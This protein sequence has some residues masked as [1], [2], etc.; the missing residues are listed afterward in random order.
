MSSNPLVSVVTPSYNQEAFIEDALRS[1]INQDYP[2]VEH[3][4][5][6][7]G[8]TDGTIDILKKY[9]TEYNLRWSS[10][11]DNGQSDAVNKG[12]DKAE[13][14]IVGWLN[15]DDVYFSKSTITDI[16][17]MFESNPG[18]DVVYGDDVFLDESG[19]IIRARKLY[20][21][22]FDRML[23]WGWWGWTPASEASFYR[24]DVVDE[25]KLD[26]QLQY[27]LDY[28]YF[29]RLGKRYNFQ[30]VDSIIAGKRKHEQ[31]KSSNR[32]KVEK[33]AES[34]MSEYGF[35]FSPL[36]RARLLGTL[37]RTQVQWAVGLPLLF[38]AMDTEFAF[39]GSSMSGCKA[40][41]KQL[42]DLPV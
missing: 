21:W 38:E 35:D 37:L 23:R 3:I 11:P 18:I 6:D 8:S 40:T 2:N 25:E 17:D 36:N 4:V 7:G 28:E 15:S 41:R 32:K 29:L 42:P 14:E 30:H 10:E 19:T 31:T 22:D 13:G 24:S 1:V 34:V 20:D 27:V 26:E 9:E 5:T 16:V 33:E 12:F 39:D